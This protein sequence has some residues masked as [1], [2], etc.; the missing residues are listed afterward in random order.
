MKPAGTA[1]AKDDG[2]NET[3]REV[4]CDQLTLVGSGERIEEARF[5]ALTPRLS[6]QNV[7]HKLILKR[8]VCVVAG[9]GYELLASI[10]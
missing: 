5:A 2:G 4:H 7:A 8:C 3:N 9:K 10:S 6:A 1:C